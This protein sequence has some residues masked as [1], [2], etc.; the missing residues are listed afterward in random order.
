M[1]MNLTFSH[2]GE[3]HA[4]PGVSGCTTVGELHA[5]VAEKTSMVV[6]NFALFDGRKYL[7][8][9]KTLAERQVVDGGRLN[10]QRRAGATQ[11]AVERV[12]RLGVRPK[13]GGAARSIKHGI[14][15]AKED[16]IEEV[17]SDGDATRV[18]VDACLTILTGGEVPRTPGQTD[19]ERMKQIRSSKQSMNNELLDIREREG[20]RL[21]K[22][23]TKASRKLVAAAEVADGAV[24]LVL[25][26]ATHEE[27]AAKKQEWAVQYKAQ[28]KLLR[29]RAKQLDDDEK[30]ASGL[31]GSPGP[32]PKRAKVTTGLDGSPG[33]KPKRVKGNAGKATGS[34]D[35]N[36][37][38][39][40]TGTA[41]AAA[42][43]TAAV[44]AAAT[45][46]A[47]V[48]ADMDR[49]DVYLQM[50]NFAALVP[51]WESTGAAKGEAGDADGPAWGCEF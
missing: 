44:T 24:Q 32:K 11:Q 15:V 30:F 2:G 50:G 13:Q 16:I 48:T 17:I 26:V 23:K 35:P 19:K 25:D 47:A 36:G 49:Q 6:G 7:P 1:S 45:R 22:V 5:I 37:S 31:D 28:Q 38:A 43:R 42:T 29:V 8:V 21:A 40:A 34:T 4:F 3:V 39:T 12:N 9:S 41:T 20:A 46:R 27:L 18:K 51:S 14:Q 10:V 33:P